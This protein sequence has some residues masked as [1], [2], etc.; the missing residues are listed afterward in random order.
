MSPQLVLRGVWRP[1][2]ELRFTP[3]D[4]PP[5]TFFSFGGCSHVT[6]FDARSRLCPLCTR[7]RARGA[8][9]EVRQG[10]RRRARRSTRKRRNSALTAPSAVSLPLPS[11]PA[12]VRSPPRRA[13]VVL[14]AATL[15]LRHARSFP[16]ISTWSPAPKPVGSAP[17]HVVRWSR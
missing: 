6:A 13:S 10:V 4:V 15:A 7:R 11:P 16:M 2:I 3:T 12:R 8:L 5:T 1:A 14:S 17:S 9:Y